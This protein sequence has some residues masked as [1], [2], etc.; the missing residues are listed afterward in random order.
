LVVELEEITAFL[1][2]VLELIRVELL[3]KEVTDRKLNW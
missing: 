1:P 2:A 3:D